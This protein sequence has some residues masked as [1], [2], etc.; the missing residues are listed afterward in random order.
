MIHDHS[1]DT[2]LGLEIVRLTW[3]H[4]IEIFGH[5]MSASNARADVEVEAATGRQATHFL[6]L[7]LSLDVAAVKRAKVCGRLIGDA[8]VLIQKVGNAEALAR[9][10]RDP[11][12]K[13]AELESS[14]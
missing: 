2:H 5:L 13:G 11:H 7:Q 9:V 14:S 10:R 12:V 3:V 1:R 6:D 4:R 8:L